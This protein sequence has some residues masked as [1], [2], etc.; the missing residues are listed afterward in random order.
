MQSIAKLS[1]PRLP[2]AFRRERLFSR[3]DEHSGRVPVWIWGPPGA[4]KTTLAASYLDARKLPA[5]W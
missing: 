2:Q 5:L 3:L 4:G 1:Q